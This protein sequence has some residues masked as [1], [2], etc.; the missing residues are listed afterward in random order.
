MAEKNQI[1]A[2]SITG[3][4]VV[5]ASGNTINAKLRVELGRKAPQAADRSTSMRNSPSFE[6]K[7]FPGMRIP[8]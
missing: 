3:S 8:A 1:H 7:A 2:G 5:A 6:R 4:V